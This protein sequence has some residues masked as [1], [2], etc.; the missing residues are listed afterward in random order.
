[1][2]NAFIVRTAD[3]YLVA[4]FSLPL[5]RRWAKPILPLP[6]LDQLSAYIKTPFAEA[7]K[8]PI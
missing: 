3:L 7:D 4:D 8:I 6:Q 2:A 1:M 5:L